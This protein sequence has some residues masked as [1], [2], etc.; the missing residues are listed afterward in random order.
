M[1][2]VLFREKGVPV[3]D[4]FKD[5]VREIAVETGLHDMSL[6]LT[7]AYCAK[8]RDDPKGLAD[9]LEAQGG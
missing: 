2:L 3:F 6:N 8:L 7:R 4:K 5:A 9:E 1:Q